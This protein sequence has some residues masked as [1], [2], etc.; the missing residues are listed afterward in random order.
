MGLTVGD[1]SNIEW[2]GR[3][4]IITVATDDMDYTWGEL[5][6][7]RT[8]CVWHHQHALGFVVTREL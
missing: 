5:D 6:W 2:L 1:V 7:D 8:V 4:E 3:V